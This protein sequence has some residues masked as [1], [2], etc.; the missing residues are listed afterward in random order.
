MF[1]FLWWKVISSLVTL[2]YMLILTVY[3]Y[4][5]P[6]YPES[7]VYSESHRKRIHLSSTNWATLPFNYTQIPFVY[8]CVIYEETTTY[9]N[10]HIL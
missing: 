1:T 4:H 9:L 2:S 7:I 8:V 3:V 6:F 5:P 10:N